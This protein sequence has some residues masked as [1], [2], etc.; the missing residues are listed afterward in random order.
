MSYHFH[1]DGI[2]DNRKS[3]PFTANT[4][5]RDHF[6]VIFLRDGCGIFH[7]VLFIVHYAITIAYI[8]L[9]FVKFGFLQHSNTLCAGLGRQIFV[10]SIV[11]T[12]I[13]AGLGLL[14]FLI[15]M[16]QKIKGVE[17]AKLWFTISLFLSYCVQ[18]AALIV[19]VETGVYTDALISG[20][21][22]TYYHCGFN[23]NL[24][25]DS[26]ISSSDITNSTDVNQTCE[27]W[28]IEKLC[29]VAFVSYNELTPLVTINETLGAYSCQSSTSMGSD[30]C[31]AY[32]ASTHL[33]WIVALFGF[34]CTICV[35]LALTFWLENTSK[36]RYC[37]KCYDA[38]RCCICRQI[39]FCCE[40]YMPLLTEENTSPGTAGRHV[41]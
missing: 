1:K 38:W 24:L 6:T 36:W 29:R 35:G 8:V 28:P 31:K 15:L 40:E 32:I 22:D 34:P 23:L 39:C 7:L 41:I 9:F 2:T 21:N 37:E 17:R 5:I 33:V 14:L 26:L 19:A 10:G 25:H 20:S 3:S 30:L 4:S 13:F 16:C 11:I 27:F 18:F 12:V